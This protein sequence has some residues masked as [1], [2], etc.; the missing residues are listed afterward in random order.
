MS[1]ALPPMLRLLKGLSL[2]EVMF[3]T[4]LDPATAARVREAVVVPTGRMVVECPDQ[5]KPAFSTF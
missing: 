2:A 5:G 1:P 3:R 4:E